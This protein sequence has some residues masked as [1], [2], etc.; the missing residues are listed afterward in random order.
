MKAVVS[1]VNDKKI[2]AINERLN[3]EARNITDNNVKT[4][5]FSVPDVSSIFYHCNEKIFIIYG[6]NNKWSDGGVELSLYDE[7][8][9]LICCCFFNDEEVSFN[10]VV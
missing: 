1:N 8:C 4:R 6:W 2:F 3:K 9:M 7:K 5:F 10:D